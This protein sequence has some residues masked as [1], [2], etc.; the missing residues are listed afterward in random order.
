MPHKRP[1]L[2]GYKLLCGLLGFSA[3]V[4]E[5]TALVERGRFNAANFFSFFTVQV[6]IV[7]CS[8]FLLSAVLTMDGKGRQ[9]LATL[10]AAATMYILVVG[11]GFAA[12]LSGLENVALTAVPW[13]NTV[14]HYIIPIVTLADFVI[15]RPRLNSGFRKNLVWL[16]FPVAYATYSLIRGRIT[17]WYPYPFLSPV[18][19]GY[20]ALALPITGL[21]VL[22]II[23]VWG[24]TTTARK[25]PV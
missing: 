11:I 2:A 23:L 7:V 3:L 14:L 25:N 4:T 6:N 17:G 10:R 21:M 8:T 1:L 12:L 24:I 18:A 20:I 22:G 15:D 16:L 13:D 9:W 19:K 5:L